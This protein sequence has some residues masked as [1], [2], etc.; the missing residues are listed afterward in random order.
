MIQTKIEMNG[1]EL[2]VEGTYVESSEI[3]EGIE[4]GPLFD[5]STIHDGEKDITSLMTDFYPEIEDR[6]LGTI[7]EMAGLNPLDALYDSIEHK[8][9]LKDFGEWLTPDEV[10]AVKLPPIHWGDNIPSDEADSLLDAATVI[11][12]SYE[13]NTIQSPEDVVIAIS[14]TTTGIKLILLNKV[15]KLN[16]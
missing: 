1:V 8:N 15:N 6:V 5:I 13:D 2:L 16:N 9:R 14:I 10:D 12:R 4:V 3:M 11:F 7:K